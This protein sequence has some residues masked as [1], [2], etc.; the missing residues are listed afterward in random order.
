[1]LTK[2]RKL[3]Q[4]LRS[5]YSTRAT[6]TSR[7]PRVRLGGAAPCATCIRA[8]MRADIKKHTQIREFALAIYRYM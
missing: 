6:Y 5:V 7:L 1:M 8:R 4:V 3:G 2:G